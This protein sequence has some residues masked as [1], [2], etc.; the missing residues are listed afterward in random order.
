MHSFGQLIFLADD[1]EVREVSDIEKAQ[2]RSLWPADFSAKDKYGNYQ[3][4][5]R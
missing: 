2:N 3:Q 4:I 1:Y 5:G